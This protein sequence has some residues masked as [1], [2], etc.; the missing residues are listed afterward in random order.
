[1]TDLYSKIS[2]IMTTLNSA[3]FVAEAVE[4]ILNQTYQ[5]WEMIVVDGG[6]T[7]ETINILRKYSDTRIHLF[8][9]DGLRRSAQLNYAMQKA[10]GEYI[11]IM[12]SDDCALLRRLEKQIL[13]FEQHP[14]TTILGTWGQW[15]NENGERG[16]L[17]KMPHDPKTILTFL[18][19]PR[20]MLFG[21]TMFRS[22]LLL[23]PMNESL[24]RCEDVDWYLRISKQATFAI[25]PE[26][27][28]M[29]RKT[30]Q[31]LSRR[32]NIEN[33]HR[34][35]SIAESVCQQI[36]QEETDEER[37]ALS[38]L[39]QGISHY[40]YGSRKKAKEGLLLAWKHHQRNAMLIRY[41]L[42]VLILP[43]PV[44]KYFRMNKLIKYILEVFRNFCNPGKKS[45][46]IHF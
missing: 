11:A 27:L 45:S 18:A 46:H 30:K 25:V 13:Y 8:V 22:S 35:S 33:D 23:Y 4:S 9:C 40:Y 15:M 42:P 34:F 43:E 17:V 16:G 14:D 36:R 20:L 12:D 31:S 19:T 7:D 39:W 26:P 29:I 28:M 44:F 3:R 6:S 38:Y 41:L 10:V 37:I 21:S 32:N 1:M 2:V 5:N 24:D